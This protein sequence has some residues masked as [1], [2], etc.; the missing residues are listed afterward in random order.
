M[1]SSWDAVGRI[2]KLLDDQVR[3]PLARTPFP[4]AFHA[5]RQASVAAAV[6]SGATFATGA[7]NVLRLVFLQAETDEELDSPSLQPADMALTWTGK[8]S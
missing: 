7:S 1:K 6:S 5:D 3:I 2:E 4:V 8:L